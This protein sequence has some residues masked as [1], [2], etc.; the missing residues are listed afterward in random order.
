MI[1]PFFRVYPSFQS[2]MLRCRSPFRASSV[3]PNHGSANI[4]HFRSIAEGGTAGGGRA[5]PP[6][7][8]CFLP[9]PD[10]SCSPLARAIRPCLPVPIRASVLSSRS[11]R[12]R[13]AP[14]T[15]SSDLATTS[16][17]MAFSKTLLLALLAASSTFAAPVPAKH[18]TGQSLSLSSPCLGPDRLPQPPPAAPRRS[19]PTSSSRSP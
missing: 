12:P 9:A 5:C 11:I 17:A 8:S 16:Y 6:R 19:R 3:L 7:S 2:V 10:R 13:T 15:L 18:L 14:L 1:P 4:R